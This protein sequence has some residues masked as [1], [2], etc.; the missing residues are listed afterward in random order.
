M[1]NLLILAMIC[2]FNCL[3]QLETKEDFVNQVFGTVYQ[4]TKFYYLYDKADNIRFIDTSELYAMRNEFK[5]KI[6][7]NTLGEL[8]NNA[9]QNNIDTFW[10]FPKLLNAKP[11]NNDSIKI[12]SLFQSIVFV[13]KGWSEARISRQS[14]K[15]NKRQE[16][17]I[18]NIGGALYYFSSPV[19]D[20]LHEYAII[21]LSHHCGNLCGGGCLYLFKKIKGKWENIGETKCWVS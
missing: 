6:Q 20:N 9:K 19:F 12:K 11:F 10:N 15:Q 21:S 4:A 1:K 2:S 3:G 5:Y 14:K 8:F 18:K 17:K 16:R 7:P 13:K